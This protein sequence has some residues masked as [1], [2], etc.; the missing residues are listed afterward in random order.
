MWLQYSKVARTCEV[1]SNTQETEQNV[2]VLVA[3]ALQWETQ[4]DP[5]H[6]LQY[7]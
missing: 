4:G 6:R 7:T 2:F 3:E 1:I 5:N